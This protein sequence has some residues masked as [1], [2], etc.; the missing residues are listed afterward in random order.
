MAEP[1]FVQTPKTF[2]RTP[3]ATTDTEIVL[4]ELKNLSGENLSMADFGDKGYITI[5]PGNDNEEIISFTDFTVNDD[6][7]VSLDTNV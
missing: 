2:L 1:R 6:G 5:N 3:L 4:D 7:S